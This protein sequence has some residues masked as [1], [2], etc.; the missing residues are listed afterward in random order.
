[1]ASNQKVYLVTDMKEG[2]VYA[3]FADENAAEDFCLHYHNLNGMVC[4]RT[5][6]YGQQLSFNGYIK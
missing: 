4:E 1:M 2:T 5:I 3:V 6:N